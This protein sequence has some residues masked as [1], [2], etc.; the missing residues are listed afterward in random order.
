MLKEANQELKGG[1]EGARARREAVAAELRDTI[2]EA[3]HRRPQAAQG[4]RRDG[5]D[6]C[7]RGV[8]ER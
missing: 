3:K 5:D 6:G 4:A 7:G 8:G 2:P 1:Q